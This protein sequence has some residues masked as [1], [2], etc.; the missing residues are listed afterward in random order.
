MEEMTANNGKN[1]VKKYFKN[2]SKIK[3]EVYDKKT[4]RL[5]TVTDFEKETITKI[6]TF[7]SNEQKKLVATLLKKPNFFGVKIIPRMEKRKA[8]ALFFITIK[9]PY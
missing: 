1:Y 2:N 6:T 4:N 9:S 3:M 7:Y 5:L 8:K